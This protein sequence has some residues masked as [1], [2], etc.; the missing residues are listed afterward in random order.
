MPATLERPLCWVDGEHPGVVLQWR[1]DRERGWVA[2]VRY[3]APHASGHT[4][5]YEHEINGD[6]LTSRGN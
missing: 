2:L 6:R 3:R 1:Q 4:L 5:T